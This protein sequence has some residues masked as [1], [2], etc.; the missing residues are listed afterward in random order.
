[1]VLALQLQPLMTRSAIGMQPLLATAVAS[2]TSPHK[3]EAHKGVPKRSRTEL[4]A[5]LKDAIRVE[6]EKRLK[7]QRRKSK[8]EISLA[9]VWQFFEAYVM[10]RLQQYAICTLCLQQENTDRAEI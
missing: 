5:S 2:Q 10:A 8:P 4:K 3:E 1:M 7:E 9:H 6:N